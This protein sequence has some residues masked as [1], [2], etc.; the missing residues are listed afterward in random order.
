MFTVQSRHRRF[1]FTP[2][3]VPE[4]AVLTLLA[5]GILSVIGFGLRK[6]RWTFARRR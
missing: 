5:T 6:Q 3:A 2:A 1:D 4:P